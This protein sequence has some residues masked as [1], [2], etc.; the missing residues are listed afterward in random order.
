MLQRT[1]A[2]FSTCEAFYKRFDFHRV[3][4]ALHDFCVVD[5]SAFYFDVLKDRLYT[6]A[7][8]NAAR[9]SAQTAIYRIASVLVRHAGSDPGLYR[10]RNL[11]AFAAAG[12]R[13]G[14]C[15]PGAIS[16]ASGMPRVSWMRRS[17]RAGSELVR[18]RGEVLKALEQ[19]RNA[20][21]SMAA[22]EARVD[23][24]AEARCA[25]LLRDYATWLPALFIVSQVELAAQPASDAFRSEALPGLAV[26][27][28]RASG[29]KCERCWNYSTRVGES[30]DYPTVC[31]RCVAALA[32][33]SSAA[34]LRATALAP[35]GRAAPRPLAVARAGSRLSPTAPPKCASSD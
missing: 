13:A 21:R 29:K 8:N 34:A 6:F 11:E 22:L 3:Y 31:E 7:P 4:H 19:A 16:E 5:L 9:R 25:E 17:T 24:F 33:R 27:V 2:L 32:T 12:G 30:A 35:D 28:R 23:L 26:A 20:K 10:R 1:S 18:V 14:Q 15:A